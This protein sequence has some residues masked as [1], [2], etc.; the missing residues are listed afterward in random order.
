MAVTRP[1]VHSGPSRH[2]SHG[3]RQPTPTHRAF[4]KHGSLSAPSAAH[5]WLRVQF[6]PPRFSYSQKSAA[7]SLRR[8][9]AVAGSARPSA[10]STARRLDEFRGMVAKTSAR[11]VVRYLPRR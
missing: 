2:V 8:T 1:A 5:P 10:R 11:A 3:S 4:M 9:G 6:S 7:R